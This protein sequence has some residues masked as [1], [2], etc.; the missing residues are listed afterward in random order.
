ML[1]G[2]TNACHLELSKSGQN[3]ET[4]YLYQYRDRDGR[5]LN[6]LNRYQ[7]TFR[8]GALP[9]V[10]GFWSLTIYNS[11]HFFDVNDIKRNST[12]TKN[13]A[14]KFAAD[15]SLTIYVQNDRPAEDRVANWLPAPAGDF[16]MTLRAYWPDDKLAKGEWVPPPV[17]R[18]K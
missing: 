5:R 14:L 4:T 1:H 10:R 15:G 7:V 8:K 18:T 2:L 17:D 16:A 6:G 12:G 3:A 11:E 13:K 9:P